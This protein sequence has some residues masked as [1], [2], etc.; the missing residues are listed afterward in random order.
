MLAAGR[1]S[2]PRSSSGPSDVLVCFSHLR[3]NFVFQRPQHL[4]IRAANDYRV[5][6]FEEPRYAGDGTIRLERTATPEGVTVVTPVLPERMRPTDVTRAQRRL[7]VQLLAELE[8]ERLILWY[9][10]PMALAFSRHLVGDA[11]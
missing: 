10:T 3:W 9:Y 4:L 1:S 5:F 11:C 6:F 7:L 8:P 2:V